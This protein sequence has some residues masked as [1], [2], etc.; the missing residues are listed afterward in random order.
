MEFLKKHQNHFKW[1][2]LGASL[3]LLAL[4]F[5]S[6]PLKLP[7]DMQDIVIEGLILGAVVAAYLFVMR[8][9]NHWIELGFGIYAFGLLIDFLDELT[10][11]PDLLDTQIEGLV[12]ITGLLFIV[13]GFSFAYR[14][15]KDDL[16]SATEREERIKK[17]EERYRN[18]VENISEAVCEIDEEGRFTYISPKIRVLL[19]YAPEEMIGRSFTEFSSG[20]LAPAMPGSWEKHTMPREP[21]ALLEYTC[22]H[23]DGN[24]VILQI[25]GTPVVKD[26][27]FRGF[28]IV[29]R[30]VTE[31][32]WT[33]DALRATNEKLQLLSSITRHDV[34]NMVMVLRISNELAREKTDDEELH[35][36]LN[37]ETKAINTIEDL[38]NFTSIYQD[39]G[40]KSPTWQ[41]AQMVA[42]IAAGKCN[43]N[44]ITADISLKGIEI[45]AD[46]LLEKVFYNLFDNMLRH[47]NEV[48]TI[49]LTAAE[50]E[51]GLAIIV[52]DDGVGVPGTEKEKIFQRNYG[53]NTGLGLFLTKEILAITGIGIRETGTP[54]MG[55]R[56]EILVPE[57]AF[58]YT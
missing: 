40:I 22:R 20:N 30:D 58:R 18:L 17:S 46:P 23:R 16:D 54:S 36:T 55:A 1:A 52:E 57:R 31:K 24:E 29:C 49:S 47:G 50:K 5:W 37:R 27:A 44:R 9:A 13:F 42:S 48:S 56:F 14:T 21:F 51:G 38:I 32:K 7:F 11:E 2:F 39:I 6:F 10:S 4:W 45:Y 34:L 33:E 19:G 28:R 8:F 43:L 15:F 25:N 41:N 26:G 3:V 35:A 12:I 53:K